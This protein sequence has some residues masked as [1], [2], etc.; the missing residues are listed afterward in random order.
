MPLRVR[1]GLIA[2]AAGFLL[3][4]PTAFFFGL[5]G[6]AVAALAG[7]VG[8]LVTIANNAAIKTQNDAILD[9]VTVG[10]IAGT[11]VAI[12]QFAMSIL[13]QITAA[14]Q[15]PA[16]IVDAVTI[17]ICFVLVDVAVGAGTGAG[18]GARAVD[19]RETGEDRELP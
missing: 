11:G 19:P 7:G 18:I 14:G 3:G 13:L 8:A 12:A 4:L 1:N 10:L 5:F 9:G 2:G 15:N 17:G 16:T 6:P